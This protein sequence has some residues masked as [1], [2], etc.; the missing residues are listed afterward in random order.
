MYRNHVMRNSENGVI[1]A[2]ESSRY[3]IALF[4]S[5]SVEKIEFRHWNESH[6]ARDFH[7]SSLSIIPA[8]LDECEI[9]S[10]LKDIQYVDLFPDLP[11][12]SRRG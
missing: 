5:N 3:F 10:E 8:R 7:K 11:V 2:L 4:S 12:T 9:P 6:T 1:R